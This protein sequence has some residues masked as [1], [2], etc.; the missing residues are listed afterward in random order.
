MKSKKTK[1]TPRVLIHSTGR[2]SNFEKSDLVTLSNS[3]WR[4]FNREKNE[5]NRKAL[6]QEYISHSREVTSYEVE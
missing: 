1:K 5:E 3:D 2:T 6:L 4:A